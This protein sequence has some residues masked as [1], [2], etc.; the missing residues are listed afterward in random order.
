MRFSPVIFTPG[1]SR[2]IGLLI[3]RVAGHDHVD[4][5]ERLEGVENARQVFVSRR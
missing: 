2:M 5:A 3:C 4:I 1:C